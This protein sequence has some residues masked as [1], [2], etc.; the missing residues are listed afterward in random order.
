MLVCA[1][2]DVCVNKR[3]FIWTSASPSPIYLERCS[4]FPIKANCNFILPIFQGIPFTLT[5]SLLSM[6]KDHT[7]SFPACFC[8][9]LYYPWE[10][11][12]FLC[13]GCGGATGTCCGGL[14]EVPALCGDCQDRTANALPAEPSP[15]P[16]SSILN[17]KK[18]FIVD[19]RQ[20][21]IKIVWIYRWEI[22]LLCL[23][24][25]MGGEMNMFILDK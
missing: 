11:T 18:G 15:S 9:W 13:V 12:L 2:L 8:V 4:G 14:V 21:R 1:Q 16:F 7:L 22:L 23:W 5:L 6:G 17:V 19:E 10:K 20:F 25:I 24:L 3:G